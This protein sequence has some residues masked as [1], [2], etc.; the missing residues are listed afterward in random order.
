VAEECRRHSKVALRVLE[1]TLLNDVVEPLLRRLAARSGLGSVRELLERYEK[2]PGE[3]SVE[4]LLV[5]L[6]RSGRHGLILMAISPLVGW[7]KRRGGVEYEEAVAFARECGLEKT[8]KLLVAYPNIGAKLV[9]L[10]NAL[11]GV[12]RVGGGAEESK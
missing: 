8:Y 2:S 6:K 10:L 9:E 1:D 7:V 3:L 11:A 4:R 5:A 12:E